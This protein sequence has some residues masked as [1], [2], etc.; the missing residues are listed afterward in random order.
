MQVK[1]FSLR[2]GR[3]TGLNSNRSLP[4][5]CGYSLAYSEDDY[6]REYDS[7]DYDEMEIDGLS[8]KLFVE[9]TETLTEVCSRLRLVHQFFTA[10]EGKNNN[11]TAQNTSAQLLTCGGHCTGAKEW[12]ASGRT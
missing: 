6:F 9:S 4:V 1:R 12:I 3:I 11:T 8:A 2:E 7:D 5:A 10:I